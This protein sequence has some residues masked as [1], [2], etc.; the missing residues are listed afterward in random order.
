MTEPVQ[1]TPEMLE[2]ACIQRGQL[3]MAEDGKTI[4]GQL[5]CGMELQTGM[6]Y[7]F[8]M[9]LATMKQEL[10]IDPDLQGQLRTLAV[11]SLVLDVEGNMP[12]LLAMQSLVDEDMDV[13]F[14]AQQLLKKKRL[15][16]AN[17]TATTD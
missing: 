14:T 7:D 4:R 3:T 9:T 2:T 6:G 17:N 15:R 5:V 8:S 16:P 12:D 13:L 1:I 11:Y 10:A